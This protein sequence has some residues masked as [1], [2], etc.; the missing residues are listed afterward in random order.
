MTIWRPSTSIRF[1]ALGLHWHEGRL[2]AAEVTDDA[3]RIKGVR[4]LGGTVAFG[5]SAEAAVIR[6]FAEELGVEITVA[7]APRY[8]ENIYRHEGQTGHEVLALFDVTFPHG[9]FADHGRFCFRED[10]GVLCWADW[11]DPVTL[12]QP[13]A[14]ALY[15]SGLK[16]LLIAP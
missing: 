9:R 5:E 7:G 4:P 12:D 13:G 1:K 3:G 10:N 8:L 15:P 16:R 2:L 6:E 11:F 14:P